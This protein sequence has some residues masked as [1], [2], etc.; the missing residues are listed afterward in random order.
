MRKLLPSFYAKDR[1]TWRRWLKSNH[2]KENNV[3]LILH[4]K[5]STK[6]SVSYVE[7]VE[8]GL[9]FGWI[10]SVANK[11]DDTTFVM[12]FASRKPKSVWSKINKERIHRMISTGL[13]M[14]A[15]LLKIEEAKKDGSWS[16]LDSVD[17]LLMPPVLKKGFSK[18]KKAL[19][20]F[21]GFP[22]SVKK[23]IYHWVNTAKREETLKK[24][25][26]E[27]VTLAAKNIRA[28]QWEKKQ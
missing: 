12:Y 7:A 3:W 14:P 15:G 16:T 20:N 11:R 19:K 1:S 21:E 23:Q 8:E 6:P 10:D 24:R 4:K 9:C 25:I 18:S 13:M 27:T 5:G 28:N 26:E 22:S 17:N 2:K